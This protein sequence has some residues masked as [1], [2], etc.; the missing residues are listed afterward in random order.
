MGA[1]VYPC[2]STSALYTRNRLLDS[3]GRLLDKDNR[4]WSGRR[5][6]LGL[7]YPL[8]RRPRLPGSSTSEI[9]GL[10][11]YANDERLAPQPYNRPRRALA[12]EAGAWALRPQ[13]ASLRGLKSQAA[14]TALGCDPLA[15]AHPIARRDADGCHAARR[16]GTRLSGRACCRPPHRRLDL[17]PPCAV[18][19]QRGGGDRHFRTRPGYHSVGLRTGRRCANQ[20]S[21]NMYDGTSAS[22]MVRTQETAA[23]F[24]GCRS[25]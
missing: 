13:S 24:S 17:R 25:R 5:I 1:S 23:P 20:L 7:D 19:C 2:C 11:A 12:A 15:K 3:S 18:C 22:T 8:S 14:A 6:A 16:A 4:S 9:F 10:L 21:I